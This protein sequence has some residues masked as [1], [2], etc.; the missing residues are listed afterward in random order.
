ML[1]T[2]LP[3]AGPPC[4]VLYV[5]DPPAPLVCQDLRAAHVLA[6]DHNALRNREGGQDI[7]S[8]ALAAA[9]AEQVHREDWQMMDQ[10]GNLYSPLVCFDFVV[11]RLSL[12]LA[13]GHPN[14]DGPWGVRLGPR[15]RGSLTQRL[16]AP[17]KMPSGARKASLRGAIRFLEK[18]RQA[19]CPESVNTDACFAILRHG[20]PSAG[21]CVRPL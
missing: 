16:R 12:R 20:L 9:G 19:G 11:Y 15:A 18:P 3:P 10:L 14:Q 7:V 4:R 13:R 8:S 2:S 17:K 6:L 5:G 1:F 21:H